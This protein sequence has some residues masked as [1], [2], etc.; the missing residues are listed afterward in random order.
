MQ[1]NVSASSPACIVFMVNRSSAMGRRCSSSQKTLA[2]V[3]ADIV[4]ET[5]FNLVIRSTKHVGGIVCDFFH[6]GVFGYGIVPSTENEGVASALEGAALTGGTI[7]S[8]SLL[9]MHP[10]RIETCKSYLPDTPQRRPIW[11]DPIYGLRAPMCQAFEEVGRHCATWA[12][13]HSKAF[14][15]IVIN[16]TDG[17]AADDSPYKGDDVH[18]WIERIGRITTRL[19]SSKVFNI[20]TTPDSVQPVLRPAS[21]ASLTTPGWTIFQVASVLPD[22]AVG[23]W[24]ST[25]VQRIEH[26]RENGS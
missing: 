14:P 7:P 9:A 6:A 5:I 15:P 23:V 16:I 10:L 2:D 22:I 20:I 18:Q 1:Q 26:G 17:M 19:G 4:N 8:L 21:S 11:I 24:S 25:A 12:A 3:A 13:A